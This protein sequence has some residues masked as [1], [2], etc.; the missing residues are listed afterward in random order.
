MV[1]P[2]RRNVNAT[3]KQIHMQLLNTDGQTEPL[4]LPL[5]IVPLLL[6]SQA[7]PPQRPTG[8]A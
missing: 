8:T 2:R 3:V 6:V 5:I 4:P 1:Q 7:L